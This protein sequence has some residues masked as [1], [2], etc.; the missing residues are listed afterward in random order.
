MLKRLKKIFFS[1]NQAIEFDLFQAFISTAREIYT[2]IQEGVIDPSNDV[3][4][5]CRRSFEC[6]VIVRD[7]VLNL[8]RMVAIMVD[9][10]LVQIPIPIQVVDAVKS[11]YINNINFNSF[12]HLFMYVRACIYALMLCVCVFFSVVCVFL[13]TKIYNFLLCVDG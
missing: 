13:R 11:D 2:K 3:R 6:F 9:L 7:L 8:V 12:V 10:L 4:F 1:K 5:V